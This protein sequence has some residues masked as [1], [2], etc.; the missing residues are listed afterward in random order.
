MLKRSVTIFLGL[1]VVVVV[2][3]SQQAQPT[4]KTTPPVEFKVPPEA[5]QKPNPIKPTAEG[6]AR[7]R[8]LYGMDCAVCHGAKGDGKGDIADGLKNVTDFTNPEAMKSLT[9]GELF[10]MIRKGKGDMPPEDTRAKDD[11][12]WNL[13]NYTRAMAK[14]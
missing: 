2:A 4:S 13:V 12:I 5:A 14:K 7:A 1:F 9:D 3:Q 6:M 11:D 10:Y 8:K